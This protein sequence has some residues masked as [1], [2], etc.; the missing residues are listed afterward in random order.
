MMGLKVLSD[1]LGFYLLIYFFY[2]MNIL[3]F[4][5]ENVFHTISIYRILNRRRYSIDVRC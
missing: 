4:I 1:L 5:A 2:L 3:Q